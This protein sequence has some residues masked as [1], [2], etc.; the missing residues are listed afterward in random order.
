M[1]KI[2]NLIAVLCLTVCTSS[3]LAQPAVFTVLYTNSLK[4][5]TYSEEGGNERRVFAGI[6]LPVDGRI[7]L[8][9]GAEARLLYKNKK[10]ALEGPGL[11]S[12]TALQADAEQ[13]VAEGF[14]TRFWTFISNSIKDTDNAE[15]VERYHRRYLTNARA[16]ISGFAQRDYAISAPRYLTETLDDPGLTF[17]WDSVAHPFGYRFMIAKETTEETILVAAVDSE[18]LSVNLGELMLQPSSFYIWK[19]SALQADSTLLES[20]PYYFKYQPEQ[21]DY[22]AELKEDGDYLRLTP[23]EQE[24]YL[25]YQMEEDSLL[26]QAYRRSQKLTSEDSPAAPL[27]RKMFVSFLARMDALEEAKSLTR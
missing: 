5:V 26:N 23:E 12:M 11:F 14:L 15:Q 3:V 8:V 22:I 7:R 4:G 27:Y 18:Q 20:P 25:L 16:G 9:N 10:I 13:I 1:R 19:V 21:A 2:I 24:L 17:R 6:Q